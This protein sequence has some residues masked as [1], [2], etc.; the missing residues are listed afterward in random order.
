MDQNNSIK[1]G[2]SACLA[3]EPV[4]YDGSHIYVADLCEY[5][6]GMFT[7][8]PV[9]PEFAIGMGVPRAP[10]QLVG[11]PTTARA[12][13]V[14]S[15]SIDVTDQLT[16][17]ATQILQSGP[18]LDGFVVKARSP[19]CGLATSPIFNKLSEQ[20]GT[21]SGI[22]TRTLHNM[23]PTMPL[24][25]E[26]CI[27]NLARLD[28]FILRV[29]VYSVFRQQVLTA[30]DR[31][32]ALIMFHRNISGLPG[33]E[34]SNHIKLSTQQSASVYPDKQ[35]KHYASQLFEQLSSKDIAAR[36]LTQMTGTVS[37]HFNSDRVMEL[38]GKLAMVK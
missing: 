7:L 10:I 32:A 38:L 15:P 21:G 27:N 4:R 13:G 19:S 25:D 28:R 36:L 1:V 3:G 8:V 14:Q 5:L 11:E 12:L 31:Q 6:S 9:C 18:V 16:R 2:I 33:L 26:S 24:I 37:A 35:L 17:F 34:I 22:F 20:T 30:V 29:C 23:H